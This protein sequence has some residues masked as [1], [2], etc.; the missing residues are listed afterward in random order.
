MLHLGPVMANHPKQRVLLQERPRL[1]K[2][3][4]NLRLVKWTN[5]LGRLSRCIH[6]ETTSLGG[7]R[8][9]L[10]QLS[11]LCTLSQV[12]CVILQ[13]RWN[14][15]LPFQHMASLHTAVEAAGWRALRTVAVESIALFPACVKG[16]QTCGA[17]FFTFTFP[18]LQCHLILSSAPENVAHS[19]HTFSDLMSCFGSWT[20]WS[21]I[22]C[23]QNMKIIN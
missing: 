21:H 23:T 15:S 20:H 10:S 18:L 17:F 7:T 6:P 19:R 4:V 5:C 12:S 8:Y 1:R 9:C 22:F 13:Q 14:T 16:E 2:L 11:F 3:L